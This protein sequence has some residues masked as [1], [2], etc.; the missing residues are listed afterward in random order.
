MVDGGSTCELADD[1]ILDAIIG[2]GGLEAKV[3]EWP[4]VG[5]C[6]G[7]SAGVCIMGLLDLEHSSEYSSSSANFNDPFSRPLQTSPSVICRPFIS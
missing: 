7:A 5:T 4:G 6:A 2:D 1:V 3:E